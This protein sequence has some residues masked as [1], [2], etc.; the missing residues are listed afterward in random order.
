MLVYIHSNMLRD[1]TILLMLTHIFMVR[2]LQFCQ[3][4][5]C[6]MVSKYLNFY[7]YDHIMRFSI[8]NMIFIILSLNYLL[9]SFTYFLLGCFFLINHNSFFFTYSIKQYSAICMFKYLILNSRYVFL[10][11]SVFF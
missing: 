7:L 4:I 8:L 10:D 1:S 3:T 2:L 11:S 6:E 9:T 5:L